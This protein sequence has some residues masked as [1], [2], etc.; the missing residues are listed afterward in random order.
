MDVR[1]DYCGSMVDETAKTCPK[2]GA[3][4]S[5]VNRVSM[6]QPKTIEE[7][8][9]WY[10]AHNLPPEEVT[11]F[12]VGK[13]IQEPKAFGIYKTDTGDCVVYKNKADGTRAV[14]YQGADEAYAVNELYQRLKAEI[15]DQKSRQQ[16]KPSY[17]DEKAAKRG[18][19]MG[20]GC[21]ALFALLCGIAVLVAAFDDSAPN[22]YYKYNDTEYYCQG[23]SWYRYDAATDAWDK[24]ESLDEVI[25]K[26]NA[27]D[28]K[29][30][31]HEGTRFESTSWYDDGSTSDD[32][33]WDDDDSW[34]SDDSWDNSSTDWDSDW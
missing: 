15:V 29:Y 20:C 30:A 8:Q 17:K 19:R 26:D 33:D 10:Q 18:K 32:G 5:G 28:Y 22:G 16:P 13:N 1:C 9:A 7:L 12:F 27:A 3:P 24:T 14:R 34:S 21:L 23:S 11:R 31:N 6:E 2:C 4:L 25:N